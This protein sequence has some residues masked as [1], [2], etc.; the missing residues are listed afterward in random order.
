MFTLIALVTA[1]AILW[2]LVFGLDQTLV[3]V[4][5]IC[6]ILIGAFAFAPALSY[7]SHLTGGA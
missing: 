7:L 6:F 1:F 2:F 3:V 5:G 4:I